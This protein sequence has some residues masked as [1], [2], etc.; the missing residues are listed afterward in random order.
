MPPSHLRPET[1]A[2]RRA[3]LVLCAIVAGIAL[4]QGA[5]AIGDRYKLALNETQSLPAWAFVIDR[6]QRDPQ[7][8]QFFAFAA[9]PNPY[10]PAGFPFTKQVLGV[11]G[12]TVTVRGRAFFIGG[13]PVGFA[14]SADRDGRSVVMASGGII[15]PG[16]YFMATP[17]R[18]SLDSRYAVIGLIERSRLIDR[19]YPV[20]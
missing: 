18:D 11:P 17:S 3:G 4:V 13:K 5:A 7:R 1:L 6:S 12:D 9:P 20:M 19:A 8:G 14:K 15:P 10:Y 16:H 2:R